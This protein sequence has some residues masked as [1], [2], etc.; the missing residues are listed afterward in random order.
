[1][2]FEAHRSRHHSKFFKAERILTNIAS[3]IVFIAPSEFRDAGVWPL[4]RADMPEI[5]SMRSIQNFTRS[6]TWVG[7]DGGVSHCGPPPAFPK[8]PW[9]TGNLCPGLLII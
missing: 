4:F 7:I 5:F 1:M 3:W 9:L 2:I 8:A 6:L